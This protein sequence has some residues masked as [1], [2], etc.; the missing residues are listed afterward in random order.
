MTKRRRVQPPVQR[1]SGPGELVQ[2]V[3]Y[4]LGFHPARSLVLVGMRGT[5]LVVTA[6]LDLA[7]AQSGGIGYTIAALAHAGST[8]VVVAVYDDDARIDDADDLPWHQLACD[9]EADAEA[10]GCVLS[11]VLLVARGRYWS[12]SCANPEC[13]PPEGTEL[14]TGP[15]AFTAAATYTGMV[16]LPDRAAVEAL[17]EPVPDDERARVK[18][19][20]EQAERAAVAETVAGRGHRYE[21]SI[22]R[23][24]FAA[25]RA[26]AEPG[27]PGSTADDLVRFAAALR[28]IGIRD[29]VWMAVDDRRIDGRELWRELARRLPSPYDVAPLFLYGWASW[30]RGA[31][32]L[33]R[34]A[35]ER[36]IASDPEYAAADLLLAALDNVV[37][38]RRM[39]RLRAAKSA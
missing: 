17:L 22:K 27:W 39:P 14:D 19:P 20:I 33:T 8:S 15:S 24:I 16:A 36:A 34:V 26:A 35:A 30:R 25:A 7:D 11:D 21:R 13:C 32:A 3:P 9:V 29:A 38:P 12:L 1:I 37:D 31:G 5:R 23:A 4:L 2:A 10:A 18:A 6:R 28:V